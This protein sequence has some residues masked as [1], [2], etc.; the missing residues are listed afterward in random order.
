MPP[1]LTRRLVLLT[2]AVVLVAAACSSGGGADTD[3]A[4]N[5]GGTEAPE[6]QPVVF[7]DPD[8]ERIDPA[9]AGLDPAAVDELVAE[10]EATGSHCLAVTHNGR[11]VGEWNFGDW[12][13]DDTTLFFSATKSMAS[14]LVGI[15]QDEGLLDIDDPAS[16]YITEWQGTESE[17]VTIRDL[18]G[19]DS[20]RFWSFA[21]DYEQMPVAES[22][23]DFSVALEQQHAPGDEWEYNNAAIQ[24][25]EA[26]L[27]GA[28]DEDPVEFA[29]T[30]FVEPLGMHGE[31]RTDA[32][33]NLQT[34]MGFDGN[35]T[36]ALRFGNLALAGGE[37]NGEQLVSREWLDE[38][39]GQPSQEL[40][41]AYGFL[42]WRNVDGGWEDV[43]TGE[44]GEGP[45]WSDVPDDAYAALGAGGQ[46]VA[47]HPSSGLVMARLAPLDALDASAGPLT[48][49]QLLAEAVVDPG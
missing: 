36:D 31:W 49:Q 34:Y 9:D 1:S 2:A 14:T 44:P 26:V 32:S 43:R 21:S 4:D 16:D 45:F 11:L 42:W 30:R 48:L 22:N 35:C 27:E 7:P 33:G 47:V 15:A 5:S 38:A 6:A 37:W 25:L 46:T 23:T 18:L 19:N 41:E 3:T 40:N 13:S 8:W 12:T 39:T 29:Q 24:T 10:A 17:D 28:L 20:G